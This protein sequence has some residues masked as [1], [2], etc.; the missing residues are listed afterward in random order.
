MFLKFMIFGL[1][2]PV[3]NQQLIKTNVVGLVKDKK[4]N[5]II[6]KDMSRY[7][8]VLASRQR[9]KG[10]QLLRQEIDILKEQVKMLMEK[11]NI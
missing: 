5:M 9:D 4:T 10:Y 6:N 1:L 2:L 3:P 8:Q 7:Q 11:M